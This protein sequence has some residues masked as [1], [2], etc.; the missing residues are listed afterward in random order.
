MYDFVSTEGNI[1]AKKEAQKSKSNKKAE[2]LVYLAK[3]KH[4]SM[5]IIEE[6]VMNENFS[7]E[8][9]NNTH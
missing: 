6:F 5:V 2:Q 4:V 9:K 1:I 8:K 3:S 7:R